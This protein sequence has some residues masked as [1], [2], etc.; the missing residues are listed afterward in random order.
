MKLRELD[1]FYMQIALEEACLAEKNGDIPCGAI[2]VLDDRIIAKAHNQIELLNDP[3]AHA[4]ILAITQAAN[5]IKNWRLN[6]C[7]MYVTKEPCVMCSGA[8]VSARIKK[9]VWAM[10]DKKCGGMSKFNILSNDNLNHKVLV[11]SGL[12]EE[13]SKK[14]MQK[15][16]SKIRKKKKS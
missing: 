4:E 16:F 11:E 3:T 15:F 7:I 9:V 1:N 14:M 13:E 2:I 10:T 5:T 12:L 8:I 6:D